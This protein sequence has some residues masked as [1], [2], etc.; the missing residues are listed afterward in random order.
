MLWHWMLG[1]GQSVE[2]DLCCSTGCWREG[3]SVELDLCCS[4]GWLEG[5]ATSLWS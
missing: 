2:L 3:Q 1:E 4:T 5:G